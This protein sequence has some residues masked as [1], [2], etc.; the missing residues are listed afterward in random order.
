VSEIALSARGLYKSFGSLVV[1]SDIEL[2]LP[3]GAPHCARRRRHHRA[4]A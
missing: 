2:T 1:A 4:A 3:A